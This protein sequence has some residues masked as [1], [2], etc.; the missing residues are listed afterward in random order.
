MSDELLDKIRN[1]NDRRTLIF[2]YEK[3]IRTLEEEIKEEERN[4]YKLCNHDWVYDENCCSNEKTRYICKTC[5]LYKNS[6]WYS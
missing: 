2:D 5:N 3:K 6:F 1:Q 4:I